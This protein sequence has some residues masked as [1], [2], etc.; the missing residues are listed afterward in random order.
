MEFKKKGQTM[1]AGITAFTTKLQ[2]EME[3][4]RQVRSWGYK[5]AFNRLIQAEMESEQQV[6]FFFLFPSLAFFLL[7]PSSSSF[8]VLL[9]LFL[10]H[11]LPIL[12]SP[13]MAV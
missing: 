10:P 6:L 2:G 11:I 1:E 13:A 12:R 4:A 5:G 7:P 9:P 8:L 3:S